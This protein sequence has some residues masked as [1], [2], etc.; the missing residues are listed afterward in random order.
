[1]EQN[2]AAGAFLELLEWLREVLLQDAVF[3]IQEYPDHPI[4][5]DPVFSS[6]EFAAFAH[7][8]REVC[9][10]AHKDSHVMAIQKAVPA[11]AEKLHSIATQQLGTEKL[12]EI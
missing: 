9:Q 6:P 12:V 10:E 7:H 11:V 4:F 2:K 8:V 5:K 1:M 3:F